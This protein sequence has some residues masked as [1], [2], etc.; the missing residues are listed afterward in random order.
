M[1]ER[2]DDEFKNAHISKPSCLSEGELDEENKYQ[3]NS[4]QFSDHNNKISIE[5]ADDGDEDVKKLMLDSPFGD[6]PSSSKKVSAICDEY[7]ICS[8]EDGP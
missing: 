7:E 3:Q 2:I 1:V 5:E 4:D 6:L 8:I